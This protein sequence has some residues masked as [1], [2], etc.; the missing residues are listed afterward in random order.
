[1][2]EPP[3]LHNDEAIAESLRTTSP[4][5]AVVTQPLIFP[6]SSA[7]YAT[8]GWM[9]HSSFPNSATYVLRVCTRCWCKWNLQVNAEAGMMYFS[10]VQMGNR[11]KG[12]KKRKPCALCFLTV[13][14]GMVCCEFVCGFTSL[15]NNK[16]L[17]IRPSVQRRRQWLS[18]RI[19]HSQHMTA[20]F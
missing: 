8:T 19:K 10:A 13:G 14:H 15:H 7:C 9:S 18:H 20:I 16:C 11:A 3:N 1:M 2:S 5:L 17:T 4:S 6:V 12:R